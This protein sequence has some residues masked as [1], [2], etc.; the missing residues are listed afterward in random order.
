LYYVMLDARLGGAL[1]LD[2][3]PNIIFI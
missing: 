3:E 2:G 1:I